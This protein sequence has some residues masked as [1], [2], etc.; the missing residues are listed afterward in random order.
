MVWRHWPV[1]CPCLPFTLRQQTPQIAAL[2]C[3]VGQACLTLCSP[4]DCSLPSSSVHGILQARILEWVAV[5]PPGD[6]PQP[7]IE[8]GSLRSPT[9][10]G[11]FFITSATREAKIPTTSESQNVR[12]EGNFGEERAP[13]KAPNLAEGGDSGVHGFRGRVQ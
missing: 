10:A 7:E 5:P 4:M 9:L 3:Y 6:L 11:R 13:Q 2:Q 8:P 12:R 1:A